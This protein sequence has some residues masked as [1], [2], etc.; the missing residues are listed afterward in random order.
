M[1]RPNVVCDKFGGSA[2]KDY[3]GFTSA[4]EY[5]SRQI[6]DGYSPVA[7]VSAPSGVSN[8]LIDSMDGRRKIG[9]LKGELHA[10]YNQILE[11]VADGMER[12]LAVK[13][14][15]K[16]LSL[17]EGILAERDYDRFLALGENHSGILL[18][19]AL[20]LRGICA[21]YTD[22]C[23]AGVCVNFNGLPLVNASIQRINKNLAR[24]S[25]SVRIVGGYVGSHVDNG[26]Y[27]LMGRNSTDITGALVSRALGAQRYEIIKEVPGI[28][29]VEPEFCKTDIVPKLSYGEAGQITWRGA[30][31]IHP[32]AV[33]ISKNAGLMIVVKSMEND[34]STVISS[35]SGTTREHP[36]A[37]ISAGNFLLI[38]VRDSNIRSYYRKII[39]ELDE[40]D[41]ST[42]ETVMPANELCVVMQNHGGHEDDYAALLKN[43]LEKLGHEP[44]VSSRTLG[45]IGLTGDA[46]KDIPGTT[47][48]LTGIL[49]K[50]GINI[51]I[52]SQVDVAGPAINLYV[53]QPDMKEAV[54][55]FCE[56]LF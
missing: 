37:V 47:S 16:E 5:L 19:H 15:E 3:H 48:F 30:K 56:E 1:P 26:K 4:A 36:V 50:R 21:S 53:K 7:V 41:N 14:I 10:N 32:K 46:M 55:A 12:K 35:E 31:V 40:G 38:D 25:K 6:N 45:G 23:E 22:G 52:S 54:N 11:N 33:E 13:E 20:G 2:F 34:G 51:V 24:K 49:G 18:R 44:E 42:F 28:Y 43:H 29:R 17:M 27:K 9:D 39:D 8:L